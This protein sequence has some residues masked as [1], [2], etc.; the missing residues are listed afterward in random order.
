MCQETQIG[1]HQAKQYK[2]CFQGFVNLELYN[3]DFN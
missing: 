2:I 3:L 1:G